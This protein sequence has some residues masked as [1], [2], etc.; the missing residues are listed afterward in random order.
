MIR[1]LAVNDVEAY[2]A[3][4]QRALRECPL[5]FSASAESDFA[6]SRESLLPQLQRRPEWMLFGAFDGAS[7]AGA[8]GLMRS[9]HGKAAH[10]THV[11]GM[12][13]AP[14]HRGRAFGA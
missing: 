4:R 11:W 1:V 9:R 13:V 2:I 12:H 3:L 7:L 8:V 14:E 6:S 5:A 10:R